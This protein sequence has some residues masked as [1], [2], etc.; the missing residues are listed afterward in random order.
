MTGCR[1]IRRH[2]ESD[3]ETESL[4]RWRDISYLIHRIGDKTVG[5][6]RINSGRHHRLILKERMLK[7]CGQTSP[8][9]VGLVEFNCLVIAVG[10]QFYIS[11]YLVLGTAESDYLQVYAGI[12]CID[13]EVGFTP[14]HGWYRDLARYEI[15]SRSLL[16]VK[17]TP[18]I[19]T[20]D[21]NGKPNWAPIV[22]TNLLLAV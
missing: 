3:S 17:I 13:E 14:G 22:M 6:L 2:V 15:Y 9:H 5:T 11:C 19:R 7:T 18:E 10:R 16:L 4:E 12:E 20:D 8:C 21:R 1:V